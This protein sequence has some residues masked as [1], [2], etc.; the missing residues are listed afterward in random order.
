MLNSILAQTTTPS[1]MYFN[2][3][4]IITFVVV[5]GLWAWVGQWIN[6]DTKVVHT[7]RGLWNNVYLLCGIAAI[8]PWFTLPVYF[9]VTLP[10]F[11]VVW[12]TVSFIYLLHRNGRVP[13]EEQILNA[14]H[15]KALLAR[16]KKTSKTDRRFTFISNH[17][18]RL[19][20]PANQD[21][22]YQGFV[23]AEEMVYDMWN[24]R[25]VIAQFLPVGE[26]VKVHYAIDGVTTPVPNRTREDLDKAIAYLKAV[27]NLDVEDRRK[28]QSSSFS[29]EVEGENSQWRIQ[30]AGSTRGEQLILEQIKEAQSRSLEALGFHPDQLQAMEE[31]IQGKEGV[32]L[33]CG[34][35]KNGVTSTLYSIIRK[36]D[37]FTQN[38]N[39]FEVEKLYDLDN[40]T[41][42]VMQRGDNPKDAHL[43]LQSVVRSDP[44]II[45]VGFCN[46]A[47]MAMIGTRAA[48]EHKRI[49]FGL[50]QPSTF[51][52]LQEWLKLVNRNQYV[53]DTLLAITCQ[54]LIRKLC[55]DCREAYTP[56]ANM[57]KRLNLPADK[58][59]QFYR[60]PTE[61]EYDKRGNRLICANCQG[62]GYYGQTAVFETLF[63]NDAIRQLIRDDA[64]INAIRAQC[65]K[66]RMFYLQEQAVRKVIDGTTS[67]QEV[68]RVTAEK[69][70]KPAA[71]TATEKTAE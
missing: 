33:I 22:E 71:N 31:I 34:T 6:R 32:V 25:A 54:R 46:S 44:D 12:I 50:N 58:I 60:P 67:I 8:L 61:F 21:S 13:Q 37:A 1:G 28:P 3:A 51:H 66:D 30:T 36:H 27:A 38:I 23:A 55:P 4:K 29:I 65:R 45:L 63:V 52:A 14:E 48:R 9:I 20:I 15:I 42:N 17:G 10:L 40:I 35:P 69:T 49:Y 62:T 57:L 19:P 43:R 47:E 64:P 41:Q 11:I 18:N 70:K 5:F 24:R 7:N 59:K 56:D 39:T 2:I 16:D 68:L 26:E 53:A